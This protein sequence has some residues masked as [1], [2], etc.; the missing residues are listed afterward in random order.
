MSTPRVKSTYLP[1]PTYNENMVVV[2]FS[3][4]VR[5]NARDT[6]IIFPTCFPSTTFFLFNIWCVSPKTC[7]SHVFTCM[8]CLG[9]FVFWFVFATHAVRWK[10]SWP[11]K[12]NQRV[13]T[14]FVCFAQFHA[15]QNKFHRILPP[16]CGGEYRE[17]RYTSP[18]C[19]VKTHVVVLTNC[20]CLWHHVFSRSQFLYRPRTVYFCFIGFAWLEKLCSYV[21]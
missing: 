8:L 20:V 3:P 15:C 14:D 11:R 1:R 4:A 17:S 13:F 12:Q 16:A 7:N 6:V 5:P 10:Q 18:H 19:R 2:L 21:F 9:C